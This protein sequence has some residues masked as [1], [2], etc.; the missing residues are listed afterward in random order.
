MLRKRIG[1][2]EGASN[3]RQAIFSSLIE[4]LSDLARTVRLWSCVTAPQAPAKSAK[5]SSEERK[6]SSEDLARSSEEVFGCPGD[7]VRRPAGLW[8]NNVAV[9]ETL[10]MLAV[11][12]PDSTWREGVEKGWPQRA[13]R[14][15]R[16]EAKALSLCS[17]RSLRPRKG[18][19]Q[20][21]HRTQRAGAGLLSAAAPSLSGE[22]ALSGRK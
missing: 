1:K 18:W 3:A 19:P 11:N 14:T 2:G 7:R 10:G 5:T 22:W 17:V 12:G 15:Q 16:G 20:R 21:A 13:H 8:A 4:E 9:L 6:T